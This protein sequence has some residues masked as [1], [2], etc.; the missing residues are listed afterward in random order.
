MADLQAGFELFLKFA[1]EAHTI[2][3]EEYGKHVQNCRTMLARIVAEQQEHQVAADPT[4]V[5][6]DLLRTA[7]ASSRAHFAN[8]DGGPPEQAYAW[9][10]RKWIIYRQS[11]GPVASVWA[12]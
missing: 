12:G 7:I 8:V 2:D 4:T 3:E 1:L 9:A 6:L 5:Y 10:G 11:G